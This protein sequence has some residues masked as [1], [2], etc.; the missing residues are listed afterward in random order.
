[1]RASHVGSLEMM[2]AAS[3]R[4]MPAHMFQGIS[5]PRSSGKDGRQ[6]RLQEEDQRALHGGGG[7]HAH[8]VAG[9]AARGDENADV[10]STLRMLAV[11]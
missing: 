5:S 1:M 10:E 9:I 6:H 3:M 4:L 7:L 11:V 2:E 8:E